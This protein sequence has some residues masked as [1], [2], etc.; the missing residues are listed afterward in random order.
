MN[1]LTRE[2]L[3]RLAEQD[4]LRKVLVRCG[5]GRFLAAAQ[6]VQWF[7]DI[8]ERDGRDYVRDISLPS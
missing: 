8:I 6:D 7:V 2:D 1:F 4:R 5:N 3:E